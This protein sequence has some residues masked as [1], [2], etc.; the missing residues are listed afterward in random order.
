VSTPSTPSPILLA[1]APVLIQGLT[2]LKQ[3]IT[4]IL[5]GDPAQIGLRVAPAVAILEGQL[6]LLLPEIASAEEPVLAAQATGGIDS[7][8]TKLQALSS[9]PAA[10]P[11]SSAAHPA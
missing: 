8:I 4:T 7:L 3:A 11:L 1:A 6:T 10:S 2:D 5:T 9:A